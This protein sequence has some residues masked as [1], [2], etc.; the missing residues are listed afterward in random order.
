MLTPYPI[1]KYNGNGKYNNVAPD[2]FCGVYE[3]NVIGR[4]LVFRSKMSGQELLDPSL[5]TIGS[6]STKEAACLAHDDAMLKF[7][8]IQVFHSKFLPASIHS[9]IYMNY[10]DPLEF[11]ERMEG[12][13]W[14]IL[15]SE[16]EKRS[17]KK[18]AFRGVSKQYKNFKMMIV[19]HGVVHTAT[20]D[21][22]LEAAIAYDEKALKFFGAKAKLNF[23]A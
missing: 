4:K 20:Y 3:H 1:T 15:T 17:E 7:F 16:E 11:Y 22:E 13:A 21:T 2:H 14:K 5:W 12:C 6:Y 9:K 19:N 10:R 18:Q 8:G 23:P